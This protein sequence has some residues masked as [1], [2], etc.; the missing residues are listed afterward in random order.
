MVTIHLRCKESCVD[1]LRNLASL[2]E[3]ACVQCVIALISSGSTSSHTT[4]S[5]RDVCFGL[6]AKLHSQPDRPGPPLFTFAQLRWLS[7]PPTIKVNASCN[8]YILFQFNFNPTVRPC[9]LA[10]LQEKHRDYLNKKKSKYTN[11][12]QKGKKYN[13]M[14]VLRI[15]YI[16]VRR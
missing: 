13:T 6:Q 5:R 15:L 3:H 10:T 7:F 11:M 12:Y 8:N 16:S 4:S 9:S 14:Q 1:G 2:L